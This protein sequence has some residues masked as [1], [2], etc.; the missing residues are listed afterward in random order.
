MMNAP[1][2]IRDALPRRTLGPAIAER[3]REEIVDGRLAPG[4]KLNERV[5]CERLDVSRTPLREALGILAAEGLIAI[6]P[7]RGARVSKVTLDELEEVFPV[8]AALERL[9]G[10]RAARLASEE[11]IAAIA[12]L[13]ERMTATWQA[14]ERREYFDLNQAIHA[15]LLAAARNPTL[16]AHAGTL[17]ARIR[18][19]RYRANLTETRWAKAVA[20]HDA[21]LDALTARDG[22]RLGSRLANHLEAT[23]GALRTALTEGI[24][25][26]RESAHG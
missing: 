18:R 11:E 22:A 21:I 1:G 26:R 2:T 13:T 8:M 6:S 9:T 3:L 17:D 19:G 10:E 4:L 14:R 25:R 7:H 15:G 5:L 20:E 23:L 12:R 16:A 24:D